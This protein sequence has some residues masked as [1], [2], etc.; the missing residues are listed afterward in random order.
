[1]KN[2]LTVSLSLRLHRKAFFIIIIILSGIHGY[3]W[4]DLTCEKLDVLPFLLFYF[5][6]QDNALS[7]FIFI[8]KRDESST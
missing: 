7:H 6:V 4:K 1:M 8:K 3:M 2:E 5:K